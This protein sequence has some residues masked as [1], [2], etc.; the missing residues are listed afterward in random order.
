MDYYYLVKTMMH[1]N[2]LYYKPK[3][4]YIKSEGSV[5]HSIIVGK[6][7]CKTNDNIEVRVLIDKGVYN[8]IKGGIYRVKE[9]E[10][11]GLTIYD[12]DWNVVDE[13]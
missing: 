10:K 11:K 1:N 7:D 5:R 8:K 6:T 9:N 13:L 4:W 2:I 3:K 12:E